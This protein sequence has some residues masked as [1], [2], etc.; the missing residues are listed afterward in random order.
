MCAA[1]LPVCLTR[2]PKPILHPPVI[3]KSDL[4]PV[5]GINGMRRKTKKKHLRR[6][7]KEKQPIRDTL[8]SLVSASG[9]GPVIW[10][11]TSDECRPQVT[12]SQVIGS[13]SH[14]PVLG[15]SMITFLQISDIVRT[16]ISTNTDISGQW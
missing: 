9:P 3:N 7:E 13:K 5:Q 14:I 8:F 2:A 4:K 16:P 11:I 6:G 10:S 12:A 1:G 15:M